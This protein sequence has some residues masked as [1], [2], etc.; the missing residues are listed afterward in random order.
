M[1]VDMPIR[2]SITPA[3]VEDAA[4]RA[5]VLLDDIGR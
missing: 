2:G 1:G 4:R 3:M 5:G